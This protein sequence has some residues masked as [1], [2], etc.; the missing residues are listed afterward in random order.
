V[1]GKIIKGVAKDL[2][3]K[4]RWFKP[5]YWYSIAGFGVIA[6]L[7]LVGYKTGWSYKSFIYGLINIF[8]WIKD[9][10]TAIYQSFYRILL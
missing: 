4:E 9:S 8:Q 2:H 3:L 5:R 7:I 6:L 10:I 1:G